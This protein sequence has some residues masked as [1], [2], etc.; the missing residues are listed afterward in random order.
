MYTESLSTDIEEYEN[1]YLK[2]SKEFLLNRLKQSMCMIKFTKVDGSLRNM[3]C[4]LNEQHLPPLNNHI[5]AAKELSEN[6]NVKPKVQNLD[7]IIVYDLEKKA[8]RTIRLDSIIAINDV[9]ENT[10]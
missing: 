2:I 5:I 6:V 1:T 7:I 4:T 8:W 10:T 3:L 9:A